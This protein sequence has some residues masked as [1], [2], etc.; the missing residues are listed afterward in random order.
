MAEKLVEEEPYPYWPALAACIG[1][2]DPGCPDCL[3]YGGW[4]EEEMMQGCRCGQCFDS[5][6][7][8]CHCTRWGRGHK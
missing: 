8:E 6:H 4:W 1:A 3:G 5:Y 7:V 2:A